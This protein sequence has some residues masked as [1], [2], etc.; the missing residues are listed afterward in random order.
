MSNKRKSQKLAFLL[1]H[2]ET[3]AFDKN[4]WRDVDDLILY[5]GFTIPLLEDIVA[6]NDKKRYEFN[7]NHTKIRA[8]QGHSLKVDVELSVATPPDV[9]YHGS[10]AEAVSSI[11]SEG[12]KPLKRLYVHLS[13]DKETATKVGSRHGKPCVLRVD[14]KAMKNNGSKF[15][16]SN[17]GV[18][19]TDYVNPAYISIIEE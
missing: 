16:L 13:V 8:R 6:N 11:M 19:L 14:A 17:N 12:I 3:Y 18:W 10:S 9:L 5:H 7:D 2:D 1:R 15:Y 4:G